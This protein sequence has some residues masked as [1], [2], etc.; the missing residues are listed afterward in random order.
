MVK[1]RGLWPLLFPPEMVESGQ[2]DAAADKIDA[3]LVT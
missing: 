3:A 2:A 1:V